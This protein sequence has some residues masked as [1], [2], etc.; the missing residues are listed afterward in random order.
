MKIYVMMGEPFV[1]DIRAVGSTGVSRWRAER[2]F[3][4]VGH[5]SSFSCCV[6]ASVL[7]LSD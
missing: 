4:F 7:E 1:F 2:R 6:L 5:F 3:F